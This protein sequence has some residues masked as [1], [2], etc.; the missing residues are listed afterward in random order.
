MVPVLF[1]ESKDNE[2]ATRPHGAGTT[3]EGWRYHFFV[4]IIEIRNFSD[5]LC[6]GRFKWRRMPITGASCNESLVMATRRF[7][8]AALSEIILKPLKGFEC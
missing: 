2:K 4:D 7:F 8:I 3:N 5:G 1:N 6:L